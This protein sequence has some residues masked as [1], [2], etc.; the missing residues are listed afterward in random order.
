[1]KK[2]F[3]FLLILP[4]IVH[5]QKRDYYAMADSCMKLK[6]YA[7]A[8]ANYEE[9]LKTDPESNGVAHRLAKAWALAGDKE[10]TFKALDIY[11][12]N[13][14][15]N[16]YTFFSDELIKDRA[17]DFIKDDHRWIDMIAS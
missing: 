13:N 5:A 12:K 8:A 2:L 6:D 4:I 7:C 11:V 1:M 17:F 14:A 15:T 10:K 9:Y 16:N 3:L